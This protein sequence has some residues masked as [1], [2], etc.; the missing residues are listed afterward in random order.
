ME[1]QTPQQS[2]QTVEPVSAPAAE[3]HVQGAVQSN[4]YPTTVKQAASSEETLAKKINRYMAFILLFSGIAF[5]LITIL[6]IW[7]V[8]GPDAGD[9]VWRSLGSLGAIALGALIVSVASKLVDANSHK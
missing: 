9:I 8:F 4:S 2:Q 5:V 7:E 6:A 1:N 3:S